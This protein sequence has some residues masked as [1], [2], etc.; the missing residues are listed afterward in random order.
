MITMQEIE[1]LALCMATQQLFDKRYRSNFADNMIFRSKDVNLEP[2]LLKI[3]REMNSGMTER[4]YLEGHKMNIINNIDRIAA[5]VLRYASVN[6]REV[7]AIV[8]N[9]KD[10]IKKVLA[11]NTFD[12]IGNLEDDFKRRITLPVYGLFTEKSKQK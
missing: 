11:A 12:E 7:E 9:A 4:K 5:F 6:V 3:K 10:I 2:A 1:P 8:A